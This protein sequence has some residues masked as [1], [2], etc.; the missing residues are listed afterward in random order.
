MWTK[1]V[2]ASESEIDKDIE[3]F[4]WKGGICNLSY[5]SSAKE[6]DCLPPHDC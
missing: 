5:A 3:K 4:L 2:H 6:C 1:D